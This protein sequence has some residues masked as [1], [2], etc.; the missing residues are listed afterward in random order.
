[1]IGS[2]Q[3]TEVIKYIVGMESS[4]IG[5][6]LLYDAESMT[7]QSLR[8]DALDIAPD[9]TDLSTV[10]RLFDDPTYCIPRLQQVE[11]HEVSAE[12]YDAVNHCT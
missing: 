8:F 5:R 3:A 9:I 10:Q 12:N 1:V 7:M 6:L 4:L 11:K 2:I